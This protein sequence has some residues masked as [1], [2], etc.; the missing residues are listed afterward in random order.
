M[1]EGL[2]L[3]AVIGFEDLVE[4][5]FFQVLEGRS[6]KSTWGSK[7]GGSVASLR[8]CVFEGDK[9]L[10]WFPIYKTIDR[11]KIYLRGAKPF[12]Y[13]DSVDKDKLV[14]V[15]AIR[16]AIAHPSA[17]ALGNFRKQVVGN[18]AIPPREKRPATFLRGVSRP[19]TRRFEI[20]VQE[21]G[22]IANKFK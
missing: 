2:F 18:T 10:D 5:V 6:H 4:T 19:N 12:S 9:Y 14:K 7:I 16:N 22:R 11:S 20:F 21:L 15:Y 1:Y 17:S 8:K 3:R 13:I